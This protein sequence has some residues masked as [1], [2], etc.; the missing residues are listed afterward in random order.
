MKL[1]YEPT[2]IPLEDQWEL[3]TG[4]YVGLMDLPS[5]ISQGCQWK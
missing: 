2:K 1:G 3:P 4:F 5:G